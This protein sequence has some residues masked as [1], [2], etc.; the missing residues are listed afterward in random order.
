VRANCQAYNPAVRCP[1]LLPRAAWPIVLPIALACALA[2]SAATS[3]VRVLVVTGGH[4]YPTSFYTVFEQDGLAW[5]HAVS[6]EEAFRRDLRGRYDALVLYD[7][8]ASLSLSGMAHFRQFV[9]SGGGVVA[10]HHAIVSY[11][12]WPWYRELIGGQY[13]QEAQGGTPASTYLHDQDLDLRIVTPHPLT[14]G[15][16]LTRI[17]DE[18]YKGMWIAPRNTVLLAT[19]HPTSDGPVAWISAY[20]GA[21]VVYI[22]LGH[23]SEAHRDEGY[24]ALVHNAV[25]WAAGTLR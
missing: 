3:P 16:T 6:N 17:H 25:Q 2:V 12:G 1:S 11:P 18:T 8:S 19:S 15:L 4:D 23:G 22:Q 24:R 13:F 7:M 5:D 10:L 20:R 21:R 9:E 14:R